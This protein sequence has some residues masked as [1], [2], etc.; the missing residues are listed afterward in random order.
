MQAGYVRGLHSLLP[1]FVQCSVF[2]AFQQEETVIHLHLASIN[3]HEP[4]YQ[5][6]AATWNYYSLTH[7]MDHMYSMKW[8]SVQRRPVFSKFCEGI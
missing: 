4:T 8:N 1:I 7:F 2:I 5:S 3:C 6:I